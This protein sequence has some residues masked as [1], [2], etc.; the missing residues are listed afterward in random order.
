MHMLLYL[1]KWTIRSLESYSSAVD[2]SSEGR[3]LERDYL[4]HLALQDTETTTQREGITI[5]TS[6]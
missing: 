4:H 5:E 6:L 3:G 1:Y 2:K